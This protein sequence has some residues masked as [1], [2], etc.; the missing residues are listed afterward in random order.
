MFTRNKCQLKLEK[1][2]LLNIQLGRTNN[3]RPD[4][5]IASKIVE[6]GSEIPK[7]SQFV[8]LHVDLDGKWVTV[9]MKPNRFGKKSKTSFDDLTFF[10]GSD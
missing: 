5:E 4:K 10:N 8:H 9:K 1:N 7:K 3:N 2:S 6:I